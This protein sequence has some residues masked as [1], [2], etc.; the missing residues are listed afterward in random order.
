MAAQ[1]GAEKGE[2]PAAEGACGWSKPQVSLEL[3]CSTDVGG[4]S[5]Y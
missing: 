3:T 4:V 5:D 2:G 1:A